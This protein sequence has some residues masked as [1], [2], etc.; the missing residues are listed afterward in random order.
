LNKVP[1]SL[2][3]FSLSTLPWKNRK[4]AD[5]AKS[6]CDASISLWAASAPDLRLEPSRPK[7]GRT[8][9]WNHKRARLKR[10]AVVRGR[11]LS[12]DVMI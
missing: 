2:L 5:S 9:V 3:T 11:V 12:C 7:N 8:I 6:V 10:K 1:V 4:R